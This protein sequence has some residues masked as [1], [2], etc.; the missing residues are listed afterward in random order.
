M[1]SFDHGPPTEQHHEGI[2]RCCLLHHC[3]G[4]PPSPRLMPRFPSQHL[5]A[6]LFPL[7]LST[8]QFTPHLW[9]TMLSIMLPLSPT[10]QSTTLLLLPTMLSTM[11][12]L[13]TTLCTMLPPWS[14]MLPTTL[15]LTTL[16]C[17]PLSITPTMPPSTT[18][19]SLM[20][21]SPPRSA[22]LPLR[23]SARPLRSPP[24]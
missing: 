7:P 2:C 5:P 17:M 14:T 11:P 15:L 8:T 6:A 20:L 12:L 13:H 3:P 1:G 16:L 9:P 4:C 23:P 24:R 19:A 10:T 22:P 18:A 21:L